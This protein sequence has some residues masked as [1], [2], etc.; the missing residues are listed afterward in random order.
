M[1]TAFLISFLLVL[2]LPFSGYC[3]K[4]D[5]SETEKA[6]LPLKVKIKYA[7]ALF[8]TGNYYDAI[9]E[10][11]EILSMKPDNLRAAYQVGECYF[12]A[13]DYVKAEKWYQKVIDAGADGGFP[14]VF[15]RLA[16]M[17]KMQGNYETAKYTF[18]KFA[19]RAQGDDITRA[20][21]EIEA[22]DFA[23]I[24]VEN[25]SLFQLTHL[26]EPINSPY[27]EYAPGVE[28]GGSGGWLP[29]RDGGSPRLR[30]LAFRPHAPLPFLAQAPN[31]TR[32]KHL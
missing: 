4:N 7:D 15:Y 11:E 9:K 27:S 2:T 28:G 8:Q 29:A 21:R 22:C 17:Q 24:A 31:A 5:K 12:E 3:Q 23:R 10:Y 32:L 1:K 30:T 20:K 26:G 18:A 19:L 6:A 25:P 13:R 16:M 14:L